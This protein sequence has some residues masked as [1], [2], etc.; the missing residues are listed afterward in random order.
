MSSPT[1]ND[2]PNLGNNYASPSSYVAAAK[3]IPKPSFPKKE[4]AIVFHT[5][6]NLKLVDY[7]KSIGDIVGPK[8]ISFASRISNNRIC[9]YL[10]K[11]ELVDHLIKNNPIIH[12]GDLDLAIRRLVTPAKRVLISNVCPSIPHD[13]IRAA[14]ENYG[15]QLTSQISFL[16]AGIPGDEYSHILSF[17][18]QV[19][20]VPPSDD[21]ELQTSLVIAF[22]NNAHRIFLSTDK[23]ECFLCKQ[24]GHIASLC[25][26][27]QPIPPSQ[28]TAPFPAIP[29]SLHPPKP[30]ESEL[31]LTQTELAAPSPNSIEATTSKTQIH[32]TPAQKRTCPSSADSNES[33]PLPEDL[34]NTLTNPGIMPPPDPPLETTPKPITKKRK[35]DT[36]EDFKL[37][38][39]TKKLILDTYSKSQDT[40]TITAQNFIAFLENSFGSSSPLSEAQRFTTDVQ[41]LLSDL[42]TIYPSLDERSIKNRLTR[43]SKKLRR[44][45]KIEE[46]DA[47]SLAS[48][49]S[50]DPPDDDVLSDNSQLS[51]KSSF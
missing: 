46:S 7:V 24:S 1:A 51:Q 39:S 8:N 18:R 41:S 14:L 13:L 16:R 5:E 3:S 28:T 12:I 42:Y 23:M 31:T 29:P 15:L 10:N 50:L 37:S 40:F 32:P 45:L 2:T 9:I 34:S 26:T 30:A 44:E 6:D 33:I 25:P 47:E 43:L 49:S 27:A 11:I 22:E 48:Q 17:R 36:S 35:K 21:Y 19:Y 20:I 4:Q 38:E